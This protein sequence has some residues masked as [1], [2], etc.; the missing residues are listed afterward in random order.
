MCDGDSTEIF[1]ALLIKVIHLSEEPLAKCIF[2]GLFSL[3]MRNIVRSI[4][5]IFNVTLA[6]VILA[7]CELRASYTFNPS[8]QA[9]LSNIHFLRA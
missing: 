8:K 3:Q 7:T 2:K 9:S 6:I 5:N 4:M 1:I